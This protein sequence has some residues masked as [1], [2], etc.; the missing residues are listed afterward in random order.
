MVEDATSAIFHQVNEQ[1]IKELIKR[2]WRY[3][4][5]ESDYN[6]VLFL[7]SQILFK[8]P[9]IGSNRMLKSESPATNSFPYLPMDSNATFLNEL[10]QSVEIWPWYITDLPPPGVSK[11]FQ[12]AECWITWAKNIPRVNR[13]DYDYNIC[14]C[15]QRIQVAAAAN[16]L[17]GIGVSSDYQMKSLCFTYVR[18]LELSLLFNIYGE[19]YRCNNSL[20]AL[21]WLHNPTMTGIAHQEFDPL[22]NSYYALFK[23]FRNIF[24]MNYSGISS[25]T[26]NVITNKIQTQDVQYYNDPVR[27]SKNY[28]CD[29]SMTPYLYDFTTEGTNLL[30]SMDQFKQKWSR[31][32]NPTTGG[33]EF[34]L[35]IESKEI[36]S[37]FTDR[38]SFKDYQKTFYW[39]SMYKGMMNGTSIKI[40]SQTPNLQFASCG[41]IGIRSIDLTQVTRINVIG[42][43]GFF[44]LFR[45]GPC[46]PWLFENGNA[47]LVPATIKLSF[48]TLSTEINSRIITNGGQYKYSKNSLSIKQFDDLS[49]KNFNDDMLGLGL[50]ITGSSD[51]KKGIIEEKKN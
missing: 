15:D 16:F 13:L 1:D 2:W 4:G 26:T 42:G 39:L 44:N 32:Y 50:S 11:S 27:L 12:D 25:T 17:K 36:S 47:V 29:I 19:N 20:G 24:F 37:K 45:S 5:N 14:K 34:V 35:N 49:V 22:L 21:Q 30:Y 18:S 33:D 31:Q 7:L 38:F 48:S 9:I 28:N 6:N 40:I 8:Y 46:C 10:N 43:L 41:V 51:P 3:F 23:A